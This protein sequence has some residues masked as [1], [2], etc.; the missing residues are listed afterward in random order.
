MAT[1]AVQATMLL[2]HDVLDAHVQREG[3]AD[4]AAIPCRRSTDHE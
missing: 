2:G 3:L 1:E 4:A